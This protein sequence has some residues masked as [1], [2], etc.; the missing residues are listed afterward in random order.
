MNIIL[1]SVDKVK[2]FVREPTK[3]LQQFQVTTMQLDI[4]HSDLLTI[5]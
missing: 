4:S 3:L 2:D 5:R 1:D